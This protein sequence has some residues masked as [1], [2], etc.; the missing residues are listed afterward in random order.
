MA[1]PS[2]EGVSSHLPALALNANR[3]PARTNNRKIS[4]R[5]GTSTPWRLHQS[6]RTFLHLKLTYL[7]SPFIPNVGGRNLSQ[8]LQH[9]A[10]LLLGIATPGIQLDIDQMIHEKRPGP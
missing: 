3:T 10:P 6:G 4:S 5:Q 7:A 1:G 9:L 8:H 2:S